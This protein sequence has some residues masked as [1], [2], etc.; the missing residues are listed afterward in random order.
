MTK[1]PK[2]TTEQVQA[3]KKTIVGIQRA[4]WDNSMELNSIRA[5][6]YAKCKA[7]GVTWVDPDAF[8]EDRIKRIR[9]FELEYT[10]AIKGALC[11]VSALGRVSLDYWARNYNTKYTQS[12][13]FRRRQ[14]KLY[15]HTKPPTK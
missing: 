8:D 11:A 4:L 7:L 14:E 6:H 13:A 10:G 1:L 2:L 15:P 3:V 12:G 5:L 9:Q